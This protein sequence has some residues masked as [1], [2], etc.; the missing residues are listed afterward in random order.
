MSAER[1][2][3]LV[4]RRRAYF[5]H[6]TGYHVGGTKLATL[7]E[8]LEPSIPTLSLSQLNEL[9]WFDLVVARLQSKPDDYAIAMI[10]PGVIDKSRAIAEVRAG[11]KVGKTLMEIEHILI[12]SLTDASSNPE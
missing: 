1:G 3:D 8:L 4:N 2:A 9:Q 10:G 7:R 5:D 11:S 12:S 6:P